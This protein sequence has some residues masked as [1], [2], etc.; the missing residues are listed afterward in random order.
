[1]KKKVIVVIISLFLISLFSRGVTLALFTDQD[2][3]L[4]TIETGKVVIET[5]ETIIESGKA[6]VG[7]TLSTDSVRS[8]VRVF[9]GIPS[10]PG[11]K[12]I[13]TCTPATPN[14]NWINGGDGYFYYKGVLDPGA[15]VILYDKIL[16]TATLSK[17]TMPS[18]LNIIVYAEA[19]QESLGSTA[20]NAF[21]KIGENVK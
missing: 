10:G 21:D 17:D 18:N 14:S 3:A 15:T 6:N 2:N 5:K 19:V 20:Q 1:M 13:F 4:N 7:A 12:A 8:W 16:Y 9:V 11:G